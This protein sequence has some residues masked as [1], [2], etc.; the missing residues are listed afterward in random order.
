MKKTTLPLICF[1]ALSFVSLQTPEADREILKSKLEGVWKKLIYTDI[2]EIQHEWARP[3]FKF[4]SKERFAWMDFDDETGQ[5]FG[6]GGGT[7][8]FDGTNYVENLEYY[9]EDSTVIGTQ[10]AFTAE[11][12]KG[13][14]YHKGT[15]KTPNGDIEIKEVWERAE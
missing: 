1:L 6:S 9:L 8:T 10:I 2:Y 7:Y 4:I 15:F 14:W 3:K 12:K 13:K 5:I 11:F